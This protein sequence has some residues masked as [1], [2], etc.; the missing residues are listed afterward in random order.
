MILSGAN[1]ANSIKEKII[2]WGREQSP[3][4]AII[5]L[6]SDDSLQI[7]LNRRI[8]I[9]EQLGIEIVY[10]NL[11]NSSFENVKRKINELNSNDLIWGIMIDH[12][13]PK[14]FNEQEIINL[15][16]PKKDVECLTSFNLSNMGNNKIAPPVASAII[17]MAKYYNINLK[18]QRAAVIGESIVVGKPIAK[19]LENNGCEVT[20][21]N[22]L[23]FKNK[24]SL[25]D[26]RIVISAVGK[27][28]FIKN[29][30]VP[31]NSILF[32]VGVNIDENGK[33]CGDFD[34]DCY[35]NAE[36][37]SPSPGGIGP[38]TTVMLFYNL[39]VLRGV[40]DEQC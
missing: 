28:K 40:I 3:I 32:D 12:P 36:S 1:V 6:T 11:T 24:E 2:A 25:N 21:Y 4:L 33:L 30:I 15:I 35:K 26:K 37:Y 22:A 16:D 7:Y 29:E 23:N 20:T 8:K 34:E 18:N 17:E 5:Q 27:P 13:F 14:E 39:F 9:A 10:F 19:L 38:V 31:Q